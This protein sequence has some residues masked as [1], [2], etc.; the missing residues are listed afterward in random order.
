MLCN[1]AT[2]QGNSAES[3]G[4]PGPALAELHRVLRPGGLFCF[5]DHHL[6]LAAAVRDIEATGLFRLERPDPALS[7]FRK[8]G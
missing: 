7:L 5:S 4:I 3:C 1:H 6:D 8:A 2:R